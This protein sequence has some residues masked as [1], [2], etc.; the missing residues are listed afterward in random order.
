VAGGAGSTVSG[1]IRGF[2]GLRALA[3]LSVFG[4]HASALHLR[5]GWLG[6]NV[7][8]CLSGFLISTLLIREYRRGGNIR[9]GAFYLRRARRLFP[10]LALLLV[11]LLVFFAFYPSIWGNETRAFMPYVVGYVANWAL[12]AHDPFAHGEFMYSVLS[13]TWTLAV[14]EQFYLLW[15]LCFLG[16]TRVTSKLRTIGWLILVVGVCDG[17]YPIIAWHNGFGSLVAHS[18]LLH[19]RL[20]CCSVVRQHSW[21]RRIPLCVA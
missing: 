14:E 21:W 11:G 20:A 19:D 8:F 12:V 1:R 16:L 4:F 18:Q 5:G 7:F 10:A 3:V 17:I 2:D 15:P 13:H 6:V 9:L